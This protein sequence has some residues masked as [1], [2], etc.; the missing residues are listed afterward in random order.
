MSIVFVEWVSTGK[1]S[2]VKAIRD[3]N[4][5]GKNKWRAY[6]D[7]IEGALWGADEWSKWEA[8]RWRIVSEEESSEN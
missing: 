7:K 4:R 2:K 8:E 5:H 6:V 3:I 1:Y